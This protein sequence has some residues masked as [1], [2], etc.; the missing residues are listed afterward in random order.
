MWCIGIAVR[1]DQL[2]PGLGVR[3]PRLPP[4]I[5]AQSVLDT[6]TCKE[7]T[8][9]MAARKRESVAR[10]PSSDATFSYAEFLERFP[11]N[12]AC[13]DHLRDKFFP[14]GTPC[15][16]CGKP[17]KFHRI[18]GRSAYS[19]QH[20]GHHVY[21]TAG[22]IFHKTTVNLQLWYYAIFLM[23]STR[24]GISAKQLEREIGVSNKTAL[25][26]FRQ[27]R[28]LLADNSDDQLGGEGITVEADETFV[29]G[30]LRESER[31]KLRAQGITNLGPASKKRTIVMGMVERGG[32]IRAEVIPS[33]GAAAGMIKQYV[34]PASMIY[35][36]DWTGYNPIHKT[37]DKH[38]RINHSQRIYV[39][40][41]LH[42]NSIEGFF[43]LMKNGIR[44]VYHSVSA[45]HLQSY[46]DEYA[47][48]YNRRD[49]PTPMFW[50]ILD[51]V[52]KSPALPAP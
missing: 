41:D 47:F 45:K 34:L 1:C 9:C 44:G 38:R 5:L 35:T 26:M 30:K 3:F 50:A 31:R 42:T 52:Q 6:G 49:E 28:T 4:C 7:Y 27:I 23:A 15:P 29:G 46:V 36:D 25:R 51:R 39:M 13:L 32:K 33:R 11:S 8:P 18:S 19:C 2:P 17:S 48:R 14:E 24:C 37:H 43:G 21:P 40:G 16:K 20:C 10:M 22:T 12:D